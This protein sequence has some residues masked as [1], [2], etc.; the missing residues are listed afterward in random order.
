MFVVRRYGLII[1]V[2]AQYVVGS[3]CKRSHV[4]GG[5]S[6]IFVVLESRVEVRSDCLSYYYLRY[7][8]ITYYRSLSLYIF[9]GLLYI[10]CIYVVIAINTYIAIL[11]SC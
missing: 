8:Y 3:R 2:F 9:H 5:I 10:L 11:R 4:A 6:G 1:V 7:Y